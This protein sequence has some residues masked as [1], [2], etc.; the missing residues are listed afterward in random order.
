M[1]YSTRFTESAC[2][3]LRELPRATAIL[4]LRKLAE[5]EQDPYGFHTTALVGPPEHR[6]LRVGDHRV[7]YTVDGGLLVVLAVRVGRRSEVYRD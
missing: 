2:G 6:R 5:L 4:V 3:E 1:K 7:V